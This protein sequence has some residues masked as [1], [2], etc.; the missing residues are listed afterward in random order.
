M[1]KI[2][3]IVPV[4]NVQDYLAQCLQSLVNQSV[5]EYEIIVVDDGSTDKSSMI[6]DYFAQKSECIKVFHNKNSGLAQ[7]RKFGVKQASGKY[8][9]FVDSDDYVE[10]NFLKV[11][12]E[13]AESSQADLVE[14]DYYI[15]SSQG[16]SLHRIHSNKIEIDSKLIFKKKIIKNIIINGNEAVVVWNK[17]YRADLVRK[18]VDDYGESPLEDYCFN[19]QYYKEIENYIYVPI[20][21]LNYRKVQGSLSRRFNPDVYRVLKDVDKLKRACM[22]D[23]QMNSENENLEADRWFFNY[24]IRYLESM[25][26]MKNGLSIAEKRRKL[27]EIAHDS[28]SVYIAN[29][30]RRESRMARLMSD[31]RCGM[32]CILFRLKAICA[33]LRFSLHHLKVRLLEK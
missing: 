31:Q 5:K 25:Y 30:L 17:L 33:R 14:C 28:Y 10:P 27:D 4:F 3:V 1:Y 23:M 26:C 18:S 11:L 6:C 9:A 16:K 22:R 7:A 15:A 24:E 13:A 2:S 21:L 29:Q 8:I 12:Y 20:P 32:I 19:L